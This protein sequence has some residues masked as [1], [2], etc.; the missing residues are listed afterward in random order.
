MSFWDPGEG[1]N[2]SLFGFFFAVGPKVYPGS[3][4]ESLL[5]V[6]GIF[7]SILGSIC[8]RL[9]APGSLPGPFLAGFGTV[10]HAIFFV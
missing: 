10:L 7:L 5:G 3:V 6:P 8:V 4:V 9:G 1:G 2:N